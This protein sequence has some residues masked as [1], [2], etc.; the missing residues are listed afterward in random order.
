MKDRKRVYITGGSSGI[1]LALAMRYTRNGDD[2]I[3]LARD[4]VK[5]DNAVNSCAAW[6]TSATQVIACASLD[7]ANIEALATCFEE[8][9]SKYGPPDLLILSAGTAGNKI[10]LDTPADEFEQMMALNFSGSREMARCV[11]PDMLERRSGQI[12]FMSSMSG[13]MGVYGYTA[14]CASKY[15]VTGFVESLQQELH[16]TGVFATLVCPAEV[17]TPMIAAEAENVLPQTRILKDLVGTLS[18]ERAAAIIFAGIE[19]KKA[20]VRT[21]FTA[22][23]FDFAHRLFPGLFRRITQAILVYVSRK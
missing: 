3:L 20:L 9:V 23:F 5:L 7:V 21:G 12:V 22:K 2:V 6:A 19:R 15:A 1:G 13:L 18:P 4:Q 14:Y 10:F 17:A 11:L 8:I 16:G